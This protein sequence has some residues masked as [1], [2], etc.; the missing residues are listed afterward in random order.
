MEEKVNEL[1]SVLKDSIGTFD[2]D[3]IAIETVKKI[4][5]YEN[6]FIFV[7]PILKLMELYPLADFGAPGELVHFMEEFYKKG[8]EE[9]LY[10]SFKRRPTLHTVEMVNRII[11]DEAFSDRQKFIELLI[12]SRMRDDLES[13]IVLKIDDFLDYISTYS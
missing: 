10:E 13:D 1:L 8:Y 9:L 6:S 3:I 12:E 4:E 5:Q 7:E 2:Y 11:N